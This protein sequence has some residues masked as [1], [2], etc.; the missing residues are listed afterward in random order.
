MNEEYVRKEF[1]RSVLPYDAM[2]DYSAFSMQTERKSDCSCE[3]ADNN[4][5]QQ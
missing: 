1:D 5:N 2:G 3:K 4:N